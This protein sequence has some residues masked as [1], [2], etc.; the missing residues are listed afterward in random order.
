[1][2]IPGSSARHAAAGDGPPIDRERVRVLVDGA[3]HS[4][5]AGTTV[6][7]VLLKAGRR[8]L[9][10]ATRSR[11]PRGLFCCM[12]VCYECV[13]SVDDDDFVRACATQVRDGMH[14]RTGGPR[15]GGRADG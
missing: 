11:T 10:T 7:A 8:G 2:R 3:A 9:R 13:V 1:M 14:I 5:D 12:G 6:A 15:G 4:V